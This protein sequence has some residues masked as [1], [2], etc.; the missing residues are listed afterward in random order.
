[1]G[2]TENR[3]ALA[4]KPD[5]TWV[6]ARMA[7]LACGYAGKPLFSSRETGFEVGLGSY[8]SF[9]MWVSLQN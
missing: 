3:F 5:L 8:G 6:W 7:V 4:G 9:G 2:T 1:M